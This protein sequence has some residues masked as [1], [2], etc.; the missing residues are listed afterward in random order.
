[1]KKAGSLVEFF[2]THEFE[3][4]VKNVERLSRR[5][6]PADKTMFNFEMRRIN[7]K[8]YITAY[9]LGMRKH[10]M[11]EEDDT[12]RMCRQRICRRVWLKKAV[13]IGMLAIGGIT[14]ILAYF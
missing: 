14:C 3:F 9:F 6:S 5:L 7:W 2:V 4:Q 8:E 13:Q 10:L 11:R 1:M 12:I